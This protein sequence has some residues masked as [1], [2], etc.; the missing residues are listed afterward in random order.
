MTAPQK[1]HQPLWLYQLQPPFNSCVANLSLDLLE[2]DV[3]RML[4][5]SKRFPHEQSVAVVA[6]HSAQFEV[7]VRRALAHARR[8]DVTA[9]GIWP[10]VAIQ[11]K[12]WSCSDYFTRLHLDRAVSPSLRATVM[13]QSAITSGASGEWFFDTDEEPPSDVLAPCPSV[14]LFIERCVC[15]THERE[16][17]IIEVTDLRGRPYLGD[18]H[19]GLYR[20]VKLGPPKLIF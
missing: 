2:M 20:V 3:R 9:A 6:G 8:I 7:H 15:Q 16:T 17:A 13:S 4:H 12:V 11:T 10:L 1:N 18:T 19:E 14:K 5:A